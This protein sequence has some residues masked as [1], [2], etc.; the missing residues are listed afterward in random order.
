[1][2]RLTLFALAAVL[3][4]GASAETMWGLTEGM[5]LIRFDTNSAG[6]LSANVAISGL[7]S[8]EVL[9][10]IDFR[11]NGGM[12]YGLGS[13]SRLYTINTM[14]GVAT[15]VGGVFGT[16]L[17]G[18]AFGFDFNPTVDRIRVTS[19]T[20]QNLRLHPVTGAVVAVDTPLAYASGDPNFGV[21]PNVVGSAYTNNFH[22]ATT[23]TLY[24]I[25]SSTGVLSTQI[26]PNNGTLNTVG[27]LGVDTTTLTG[28]DISGVTGMAYASLTSPGANVGATNL[29]RINLATG[30]ATFVNTIGSNNDRIVDISAAPVPEPATLAAI[31][32]G[33]AA[34]ARRR[35][36]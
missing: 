1:M 28:F 25:D 9:H 11:P 35:R 18:T 2:K 26:P 23:T 20:G 7:Q 33:L 31:G 13:T 21:A 32:L 14:T 10:A 22:G 19:N 15:A 3:T 16:L 36:R 5:R 27:S 8:G 4:A 6:T 29:W 30:A 24:N 34:L 12:L 17:S